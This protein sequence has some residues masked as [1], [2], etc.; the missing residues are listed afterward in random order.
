MHQFK[1]TIDSMPKYKTLLLYN[2]KQHTNG[3]YASD[4]LQYIQ[5]KRQS[6]LSERGTAD[7][8]DAGVKYFRLTLRICF[9]AVQY[10]EMAAEHYFV[11]CVT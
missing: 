10:D 4:K 5:T 9:A 2:N 6:C 8:S 3:R 7:V 1:E 11:Y